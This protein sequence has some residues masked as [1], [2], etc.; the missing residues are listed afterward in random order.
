[1]LG[2]DDGR[3]PILSLAFGR[4]FLKNATDKPRPA[5]GVPGWLLAVGTKSGTASVWDLETRTRVNVFRG[6]AFY[7][8][9]VAFSPDGTTL[10]TAGHG[11]PVAWDVAT[12]RPVFTLS[13]HRGGEGGFHTGVKF[14]P[15]G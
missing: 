5:D 9:A 4:N 11:A 13:A 7:V 1:L 10:V 6:A 3:A 14:A 12:G 8:N 2:F 15:D